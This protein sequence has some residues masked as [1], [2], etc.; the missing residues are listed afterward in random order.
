MTIHDPARE[1][2]DDPLPKNSSSHVPSANIASPDI[3]S[4]TLET[5]PPP[6]TSPDSSTAPPSRS[7]DP[8]NNLKRSDPFQ[9]GSRYLL[10]DDDVFE[11][12]AW[13]HVPVT[14]AHLAHAEAQ[15]AFQR[16][17]PASDFDKRRFNADPAKWWNTFYKNNTSNFFKDRKWLLQE[18]PALQTAI[19]LDAGP[20][21]ILEVGAGAGNTAFPLLTHNRNPALRLHACDFSKKAVELIRAHELYD[22][23]HI[24]ADVWDLASSDAPLPPG[25]EKK[26]V[27]IV[28][29]IFIFS[30]LAPSQ[31][32]QA[33]RNVYNLLKPGGQVLFR[34]YGRGDL[35]QVRFK[36][37]RY[38]EE[39][40]YVRGDGTRVYFFDRGELAGIWSNEMPTQDRLENN[41]SKSEKPPDGS[42]QD[43][44]REDGEEQ[45]KAAQASL[46]PPPPGLE[47]LNLGVDRRL[48]VN[49]QRKITM[50]RCWLQGRFRKSH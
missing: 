7:H 22:P 47:I 1:G 19:A 9:F 18:F 6:S 2:L 48:L 44:M 14:E 34:D 46:P 16:S 29:L 13:D 35:A 25:V 5:P 8:R 30:A 31:W 32:A 38:L 23:T 49:R 12:N 17:C 20:V 33:V 10:E 42:E 28:L 45:V 27:D 50:N 37:G 15:Y 43:A 36:K 39:N 41:E 40:F 26:S 21:T 4:L 3:S 11:F 24:Q